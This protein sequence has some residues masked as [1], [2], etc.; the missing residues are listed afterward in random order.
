MQA[1]ASIKLHLAKYSQI[2]IALDTFPYNGTTTTCEAL[3]MGVPVVTLRGHCHAGRV[4]ASI[5]HRLGLDA[6]VA[7][8]VDEYIAIAESITIDRKLNNRLC[9]DLR[10]KM[11]RSPLCDSYRFAHSIENAFSCMWNDWKRAIKKT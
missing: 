3:W 2:D 4:G 6:L 8:T 7:G 9:R 11:L 10:G 1:E 5:L